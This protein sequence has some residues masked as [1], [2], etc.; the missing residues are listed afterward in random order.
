M[1]SRPLVL[2]TALT[3]LFAVCIFNVNGAGMASFDSHR[4]QQLTLDALQ[5]DKLVAHT[6]AGALAIQGIKGLTEIQVEADIY[7]YDG[8]EPELSLSRE[9]THAKLVANFDSNNRVSPFGGH[10]PYIDLVVKV[11]AQMTMDIDDG[12][13][14]IDIRGV[15]A[16]MNITDGS[17]SITVKGGKSLS[18][19]DGS[20]AVILTHIDGNISLEDG[21]GSI[22]IKQVNGDVSVK[23]G[24]GSML[25]ENIIGKVT[26]YDGSGNIRVENS[27]GL[28]IV[29]AGSG[30]LSFDDIDG[31]VSID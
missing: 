5:L 1:N 17:G 6:G 18:I 10:S 27:K 3:A 14:N 12:S 11:P 25:I 30:D 26:I 8:V 20:G 28:H 4:Q 13:G 22:E 31:P 29:E 24:S 23:D 21:S 7:G 9:G 19:N 2:A 16:D 15:Q